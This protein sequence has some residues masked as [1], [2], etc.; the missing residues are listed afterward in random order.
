VL[1]FGSRKFRR[2]FDGEIDPPSSIDKFE[3]PEW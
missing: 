1:S 3:V 2:Q